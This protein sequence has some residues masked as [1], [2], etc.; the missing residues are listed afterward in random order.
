MS[1]SACAQEFFFVVPDDEHLYS[2]YDDDD[3]RSPRGQTP[4]EIWYDIEENLP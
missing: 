3:V 2:Y 4:G 1:T